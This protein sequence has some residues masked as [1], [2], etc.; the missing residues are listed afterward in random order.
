MQEW[1]GEAAG[2]LTHHNVIAGEYKYMK[3]LEYDIQCN[4]K[5]RATLFIWPLACRFIMA[6]SWSG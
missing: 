4:W 3:R 5:V 1:V 6:Q 2:L